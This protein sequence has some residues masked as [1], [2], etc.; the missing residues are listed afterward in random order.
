MIIKDNYC[1][2][3]TILNQDQWTQLNL[4]SPHANKK[5]TESDS[6]SKL[7]S[8]S[9]KLIFKEAFTLKTIQTM[10]FKAPITSLF[11]TRDDSHLLAGLG[12]GKLI[13]ITG[14]RLL[15]K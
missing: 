3:A 5:S 10:K 1:V 11:L 9:S 8:L 13:V 2:L 14:D 7:L 12:D 4:S 6:N 15:N